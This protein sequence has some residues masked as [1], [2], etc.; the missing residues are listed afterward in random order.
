MTARPLHVLALA[1]ALT[2]TACGESPDHTGADPAW[3]EP[4]SYTCTLDAESQVLAGTFHL[5]VRDGRVTSATGPGQS[6]HAELPT[7]GVL[8][9]HLETARANDADTATVEYAP[10]GH[11]TRIVLDEDRNAIDDEAT[12]VISAY[13]PSAG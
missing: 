7:I 13:R 10:D 6:A 8:L 12:Y 5:T 1:V 11:P 4:A 3:R 2:T 9:T